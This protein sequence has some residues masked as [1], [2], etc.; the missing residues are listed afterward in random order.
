MGTENY[1]KNYNTVCPVPQCGDPRRL[2]TGTEEAPTLISQDG[3]RCTPF[4]SCGFL[5][6]LNLILFVGCEKKEQLFSWCVYYRN[7]IRLGEGIF[8]CNFCG[9]RNCICLI[10]CV[11]CE[12]GTDPGLHKHLWNIFGCHK[13]QRPLLPLISSVPFSM[14]WG[15]SECPC[16]H[17]SNVIPTRVTVLS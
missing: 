8:C 15:F 4:W 9:D 1:P 11:W 17:L 12:T 6:R 13:A 5:L 16:L 7:M 2:W 14:A 3:R 10:H